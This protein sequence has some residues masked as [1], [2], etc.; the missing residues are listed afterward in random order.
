MKK[1]MLMGAM[2]ALGSVAAWAGSI[3]PA[4]NGSTPFPYNPDNSATGCN[5]V[6]TIAANGAISVVIKDSNPYEN[7]EDVLVGVQ[8][9]S[10]SSVTSLNLTGSGIFGFDGDGICT[11]TFVGS[12]YCSNTGY[13]A[14]PLDYAGPT[15]TFNSSDPTGNTGKVLFNPGIAGNGGTTF[16]SLEG[17]PSASLVATVGS[18]G[19][20]AT[21][22]G[23]PALSTWGMA[24]LVLML[25]GLS[26]RMMK[27]QSA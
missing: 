24:L 25:V 18:T 12:G 23:A 11:F 3:C 1:F 16:F 19:T 4:G 20:G 27:K 15:S 6:I 7:S 9:N 14:D 5:V 17:A 10:S 13:K 8:N 26:Y 22:L 21:G 2:F